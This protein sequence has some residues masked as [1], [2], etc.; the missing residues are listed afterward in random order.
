[1]A[2]QKVLLSL[3]AALLIGQCAAQSDADIYNFALNLEYL[4]ANFYHCAAYGTPINNTNGGPAPTG[5]TKGSFSDPVQG[6]F[7]E[8]ARDEQDHVTAIQANLG[9]AAVAQPQID[10]SAITAAANAA[11]GE[12]LTPT[13]TYYAN[14]IT[15]L[16]SSFLF[17][18]VGVTAYNG[19]APL[20]TS[21]ALL[22][23]AVGI[24]LI[25]AYHAGIIRKTLFDNGDQDTGYGVTVLD[26]VDTVSSLRGNVSAMASGTTPPNYADEGLVTDGVETIVPSGAYN[27][28]FS[29]TA[30]EV[31]A[32]VYLGSASKPGGFFPNGVNGA[33]H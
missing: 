5:C 8:L 10:L 31:L 32:I 20:I 27:I 19:A 16:L 3:L 28:A 13:F 29:R 23:P 21:K 24:G 15:G 1:M 33:I 26:A 11:F 25:E 14:D 9:A 17:E 22:A 12:T 30:P 6:L 7:E 2:T 18:D 4:E